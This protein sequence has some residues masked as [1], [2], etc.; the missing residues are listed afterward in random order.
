MQDRTVF[1]VP[2][3]TSFYGP[4]LARRRTH[5]PRP[6]ILLLGKFTSSILSFLS[7]TGLTKFQAAR[8]NHAGLMTWWKS[9][10]LCPISLC[11]LL[12]VVTLLFFRELFLHYFLYGSGIR[13]NPNTLP[14]PQAPHAEL[15]P[16][17]ALRVIPC[18]SFSSLTSN[19]DVRC[20]P[21][22]PRNHVPQ[23]M[24]KIEKMNLISRKIS[25]F[26]FGDSPFIMNT[27]L[28]RLLVKIP[29]LTCPRYGHMIQ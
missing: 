4:M 13:A 20:D 3:P 14:N 23:S 27:V 28:V 11:S 22:I 6:G 29:T 5:P 21:R 17:L 16:S 24:E 26:F 15:S 7:P 25:W 19:G 1:S 12:L 8:K 9:I 2:H 10:F 18:D